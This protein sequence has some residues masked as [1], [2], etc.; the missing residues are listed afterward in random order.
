LFILS[1]CFCFYIVSFCL[2]IVSF[3]LSTVC[4]CLSIFSFCLSIVSFCLSIVSF[5]LSIVSFCFSIVS[6]CLFTCWSFCLFSC[7]SFCLFTCWSLVYFHVDLSFFIFWF[8]CRTDSLLS[9]LSFYLSIVLYV[10]LF[11]Y[12][13]FVSFCL[14]IVHYVFLFIYCYLCL[15]VYLLFLSSARKL[16]CYNLN[17]LLFTLFA[18]FSGFCFVFLKDL[19]FLHQCIYN[20][21][22]ERTHKIK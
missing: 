1:L 15:S 4:F 18:Y 3:C 20:I 5:C 12:C 7:W 10:F 19:L 2:F 11:I 9:F 16:R 21:I 8:F 17:I 14:S 22:I 6:F 13:F